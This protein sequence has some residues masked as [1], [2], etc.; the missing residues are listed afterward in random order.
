MS[1]RG[2]ETQLRINRPVIQPIPEFRE[3]N[4][5]IQDFHG[6]ARPRTAILLAIRAHL[7]LAK[8]LNAPID[9]VFLAKLALAA[10]AM[11]AIEDSDSDK[12]ETLRYAV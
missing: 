10:Q 9:E 3:L 8:R 6:N 7:Y 12:L 2:A 5:A 11:R 4:E 1:L